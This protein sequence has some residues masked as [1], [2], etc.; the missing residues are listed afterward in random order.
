[1]RNECRHAIAVQAQDL[2]ARSTP[3]MSR[4]AVW[5][6]QHKAMTIL[7]K[8]QAEVICGAKVGNLLH[9]IKEHKPCATHPRIA[10]CDPAKLSFQFCIFGDSAYLYIGVVMPPNM[11]KLTFIE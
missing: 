4:T 5:Q 9:I 7:T 1:M 3:H 11:L 10:P 6:W 2:G 8:L